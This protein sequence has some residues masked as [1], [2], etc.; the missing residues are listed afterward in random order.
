MGELQKALS[1]MVTAVGATA[2]AG[3]K[4]SE[5]A[6]QTLLKEEQM[7]EAEREVKADIKEA[8]LETDLVKMGADPEIAKSFMTAKKLG[9]DTEKYGAIKDKISY[10][11]MAEM[12]AKGSLADT[13]SA[14]LINDKGFEAKL[15]KLSKGDP[16]RAKAILGSLDIG[17]KKNG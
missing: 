10:S 2:V 7:A 6:K 12:L 4:L 15:T 1:G 11:K 17:G 16:E 3:K 5:D 9:L 14:R 8:A 13:Y